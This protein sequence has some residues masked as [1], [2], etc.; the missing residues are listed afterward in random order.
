MA[1]IVIT[2]DTDDK[3]VEVTVDGIVVENVTS[4]Y[5]YGPDSAG[6]GYGISISMYEKQGDLRKYSSLC[7]SEKA[8]EEIE[9]GEAKASTKFKGLAEKEDMSPLQKS[10]ASLLKR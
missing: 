7:A 1:K 8:T 5:A 2:S 4:V 9:S 3:T 10:I 6:Y